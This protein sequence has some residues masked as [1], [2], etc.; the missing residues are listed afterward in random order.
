MR[1]RTEKFPHYL[2]V[3]NPTCIGLAKTRFALTCF[4]FS[5]ICTKDFQEKQTR[6]HAKR[7]QR[8]SVQSSPALLCSHHKSRLLCD[9]AE[10]ADLPAD[11]FT[12]A[13]MQIPSVLT[14]NRLRRRGF[15]LFIFLLFVPLT[16]RPRREEGGATR[17]RDNV[18][19]CCTDAPFI[20]SVAAAR[21]VPIYSGSE[22]M[23][24]ARP[25]LMPD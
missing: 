3:L 1:R 11:C 10:T 6:A 22:A 20:T 24:P 18:T 14:H 25:Q 13:T 8:K 16:A 7:Q 4:F 21:N 9:A 2:S 5:F 19:L 15:Y 23:A 12:L 17:W